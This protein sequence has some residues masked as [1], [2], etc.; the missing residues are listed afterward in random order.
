MDNWLIALISYS[1]RQVGADTDVNAED[2]V[3]RDI[4][5]RESDTNQLQIEFSMFVKADGGNSL[6][7]A[8]TLLHTIMVISIQFHNVIKF[9]L[10]PN[11]CR[12]LQISIFGMDFL[13]QR[14]LV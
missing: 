8:D 4:Q 9:N 2:V 1:K 11:Y 14:F 5:N 13:L 12:L 6:L 3:L 10:Y 7:S